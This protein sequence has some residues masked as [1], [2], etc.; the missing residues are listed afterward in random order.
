MQPLR[1]RLREATQARDE[2]ASR[3]ATSAGMRREGFE[4]QLWKAQLQVG[5]ALGA[6]ATNLARQRELGADVQVALDSLGLQLQ[7][8]WPWYRQ[9]LEAREAEIDSLWNVRDEATGKERLRAEME[10]SARAARLQTACEILV[11][12]ILQLEPCGVDVSQVRAFTSRK[13]ADWAER[14]APMMRVALQQRD[15]L[16]ER[17]KEDPDAKEVQ[18]EL[19]SLEENL[20]RTTRALEATVKLMEKLGLDTASYVPLLLDATGQITTAIFD[21]QVAL[22][23]LERFRQQSVE[24]VRREGPRWLLKLV[25]FGLILLAFRFLGTMVR[26]VVRRS[27]RASRLQLS[28]LLQDTLVSWSSRV[29][30]LIGL[31]VAFSQLGLEIAPLLAGLGIAGFVL[32]FALQDSLS[33]FAAGAMILIYRP[34]DV[35]DFIEAAGTSGKV[36]RMSLVSTTILTFDNQTLI[37]PNSKIWGDVIRNVTAQKTRRV[38]LVFGISY[39]DDVEKAEAVLRDVVSNHAKVLSEPQ[40]MVKLHKLGESSVDFVV[41]PWCATQDYWEVYWDVTRAVKLRFDAEGISI[42]FPQRDVHVAWKGAAPP[43]E[44]APRA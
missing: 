33:N 15:T 1:Q 8:G 37:V 19:R 22:G 12:T 27:V 31:L 28:Q 29:V 24:T 40:P 7:D 23:L 20:A 35:G 16:A 26:R 30:L 39:A 11:D 9:Q 42:P 34:F 10:L 38:D 2:A 4:E 6:L 25:V 13:L 36:S 3:F 41:R 14:L 17:L 44:A 32:G 43:T 5:R 18:V 21:R